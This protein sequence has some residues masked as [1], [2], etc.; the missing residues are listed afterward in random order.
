MNRFFHPLSR[1]LATALAAAMLTAP[2]AA[3]AEKAVA[4]PPPAFDAPSTATSATAILAG[5]CFWGVQAVFQHTRGVTSAVS[6]YAG[7]TVKS[8]RYK[9]VTSGR[10]GHAEAVKVTYDPRQVTYGQLLHIFFSVVHDPTQLNR[11]GPDTGTQYRS[12]IFT[13]SDSQM[14]VATAYIAQLDKAQAYPRSIVTKVQAAPKFWPAENYHQDYATLHPESRYIAYYDLP[15]IANLKKMF[16]QQ[17][18]DQPVL[19]AAK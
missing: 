12:A 18:R 11:Q 8:P 13:T 4:I 16:P 6:G 3:S 1:I 7:G 15:K 10:T 14:T 9:A 5:G 17:Y 19:I 2:P